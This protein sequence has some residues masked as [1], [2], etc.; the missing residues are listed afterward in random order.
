MNESTQHNGFKLIGI[1]PLK[2][3]DQKFLKNLQIGTPYL[4][5]NNY[6][7]KLNDDNSSLTSI[8][9]NKSNVPNTMYNLKNGI[10]IN[11]SAVVG[12]NG[13]GKSALIELFYYFVYAVSSREESDEVGLQKYSDILHDRLEILNR[14][15]NF[16]SEKKF[17]Y[18]L[19]IQYQEKYNLQI[20]LKNEKS[21]Y[22]S[23]LIQS[24]EDSQYFLE[25]S[26]RE[27]LE[28]DDL[29][30]KKLN[31]AL[32]YELENK[33]Y[34]AEFISGILKLKNQEGT[35]ITDEFKFKD[36]FYSINLNYSHHS[37]NSNVLGGWIDTLFH[38]NDGYR[39]PVV[40]NPMR[41]NGGYNIN[42]EL[43][44]SKER[45]MF[46]L[47][48]YLIKSQNGDQGYKLLDKYIIKSIK[49]SIKPDSFPLPI[50]SNEAELK[51]L[52]SYF[53]IKDFINQNN[54]AEI[55]HLDI[56]VGYLKRKLTKIKRNYSSIIFKDFNENN[57]DTLDDHFQNFILEDNSHIT[58]KIKQVVNYL[59][60]ATKN[61]K[62]NSNAIFNL[63]LL[64]SISYSNAEFI[65][66]IED[67]VRECEGK[68][69]N[70][71]SVLELTNY[72][73]PSI[74]NVDFELALEG[75]SR[76]ISLNQL[77]SG[78]QQMIFN[79]N[80]ILYH[81]YNLQSSFSSNNTRLVYKNVSIILD[82]IELYYHPEMQRQILKNLLDSLELVKN[83]GRSGIKAINI[84]FLTHSP[85]I[86]S[87]I[88][89]Q[90]ILRLVEGKSVNNYKSNSF[91]ANIYDLLKDEF[92]LNNGAIGAYASNKIA[93]ILDKDIIEQEDIDFI[94]L[95]DDPF[96][97]G[98]IKK[99][100]EDKTSIDVLEDEIKRLQNELTQ[101]KSRHA[102][103]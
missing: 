24:L 91:A 90:N 19:G 37:L 74:F 36:F 13:S 85:F 16:I 53:L 35:T 73:P 86:L 41:N 44:L 18:K 58:K 49:L 45:L 67:N 21:N 22:K 23:L 93:S 63:K 48:Y 42:R 6:K 80:T 65:T 12:A 8:V 31:V 26:F 43:N 87:D 29:I 95:I 50:G 9:V 66:F 3:C 1:I 62:L 39:T 96:L 71:L 75:E 51:E 55:M 46:N 102:A 7:V 47:A 34:I 77:S 28:V 57:T 79:V 84:Q 25:N 61:L 14:D 52:E 54:A 103:N 70:S 81:L 30:R 2:N 97:K 33:I 38:K 68:E 15:I 40:I 98:V 20:S 69:S 27:A 56:A 100:I 11:V 99:Q 89:N 4:F 60:Y 64:N 5:Y 17:D 101:K 72:L 59:R 83:Y 94:N 10:K 92:F 88:P 32:I 82:E 78:E 76:N